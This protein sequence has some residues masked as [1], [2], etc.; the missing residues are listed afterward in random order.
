MKSLK[1][2]L[3]AVVLAGAACSDD[4]S[5]KPD[6]AVVTGDGGGLGP[7]GGGNPGPDGGGNPGPDGGG[8][9][10]DGGTAAKTL[11]E[12]VTDLVNNETN[13]TGTPES[14]EDKTLTDTSDPAAFDSLF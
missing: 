1:Y 5:S 8:L 9:N 14:V 11:V 4:T 13:E 6:A 7:D 2:L 10:P 3:V 12:F